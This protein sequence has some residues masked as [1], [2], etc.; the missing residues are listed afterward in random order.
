MT[1]KEKIV[2]NIAYF[3]IVLFLYTAFSKL[4]MFETTLFDM[5]KNPLLSEYP[6]FW[7]ISV[8]VVEIIVSVL[9][10][11]ASTRRIGL[12]ITSMM[13][14]AF[15]GYIGLLL[16]LDYDLPCTCGGIFRELGWRQHL[17]VNVGLIALVMV[18][19]VLQ[20]WTR[21]ISVKSQRFILTNT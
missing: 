21:R 12:W 20:E 17:W 15:T 18:A 3:F 6:L 10:F 8:P 13:M 2:R 5:R 19:R 7:T 4:L 16:Q 14:V 11:F 9:L 1:T